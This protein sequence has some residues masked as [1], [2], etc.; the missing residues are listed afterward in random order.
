M[1]NT[2][3]P[4]VPLHIVVVPHPQA[5]HASVPEG[6]GCSFLELSVRCQVPTVQPCLPQDTVP[7]QPNTC[8][9]SGC[10]KLCPFQFLQCCFQPTPC[11]PSPFPP[12]IDTSSPP[13]SVNACTSLESQLSNDLHEDHR[14]TEPYNRRHLKPRNARVLPQTLKVPKQP[15]RGQGILITPP[16]CFL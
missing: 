8:S 9:H 16:D 6:S 5:E 3:L 15:P 12:W 13:S 2:A 4:P 1:K 7:L 10:P 14:H 11:N